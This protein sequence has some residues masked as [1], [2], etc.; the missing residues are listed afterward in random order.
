MTKIMTAKVEIAVAL[1][2]NGFTFVEIGETLKVCTH[3]A[4]QYFI[5]G[6]RRANAARIKKGF[7]APFPEFLYPWDAGYSG[8]P[9]EMD[10]LT[11]G[12]TDSAR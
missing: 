1:R 12:R 9:L 4:R 6:A 11:L 3:Q 10:V 8:K 7:P 5:R 2:L